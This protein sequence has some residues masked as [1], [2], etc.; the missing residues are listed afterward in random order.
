M[1]NC[2]DYF[3]YFN[4][5]KNNN[6]NNNKKV[7]NKSLYES[8]LNENNFSDS[9]DKEYYYENGKYIFGGGGNQNKNI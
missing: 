3:S 8:L 9:I 5:Y 1:G 2:I 6:V 7:E 4:S